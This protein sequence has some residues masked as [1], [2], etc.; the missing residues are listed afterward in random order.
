MKQKG[1]KGIS[2]F[3]SHLSA[4]LS[5]ALVLMTVGLMAL[6]A[7]HVRSVTDSIRS[8]TGFDVEF[9]ETA[10]PAQINALYRKVAKAN[11]TANTTF[12]SADDVM[13]QWQRDTGEDLMQV[14]G[15]NP[16]NAE[17]T[18]NVK[19]AYASS[20]SLTAIAS[21]LAKMPGV[22]TIALNNGMIDR[23]NSNIRTVMIAGGCVALALFL[24]SL[25]LI[26]NTV[27]L[28]IY[29]RRF[30]IHTMQL[31]GATDWFIR[32]P[33]LLSNMFGGF[34]AGLVADA[35]LI[36]GLLALRGNGVLGP[37]LVS[38]TE[39]GAVAGGVL[40]LGIIICVSAALFSTTRYL[41]LSYDDMF[42]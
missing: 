20:D 8:R 15:V 40:L 2:I 34:V 26:N 29:S 23:I 22:G 31:V 17:L 7:L 16:F 13:A 37:D 6:T 12:R 24:I 9:A 3:T 28:D 35:A 14:L 36:A 38:W 30:L 19:A 27:H 32:R 4:T 18:V 39:V 1:R 11:Y 21:P 33:F 42:K 5:V 41:R 25:V 10:T